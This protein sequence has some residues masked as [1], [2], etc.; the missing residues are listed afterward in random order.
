M[1]NDDR[2]TIG[3]DWGSGA[4]NTAAVKEPDRWNKVVM[5]A[6]PPAGRVGAAFFQYA[7]LRRSSYM[8]FFQHPLS[9]MIV[10]HDDW[11]FIRG[12]WNDWS[13]GFEADEDIANFIAAASP[14]GHLAATLGYYR[15]TFQPDLQSPDY[16]DWQD[17]G[18]VVPPQPTL[19]LHGRNDGC[20][21]VEL[22]EGLE[23]D[24]VAGS[25][26]LVFDNMGHFLQLEDPVAV[27]NAI[28]GFLNETSE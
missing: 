7:Q 26:V 24:L 25:K 22:T 6:V 19:Y 9:E 28:V 12:L 14:E 3:H 11:A 23:A 1:A 17:A 2:V 20:I 5:M 13:P 16:A 21:G 8:F 18:N 4:A 15:A 10:P 27:N